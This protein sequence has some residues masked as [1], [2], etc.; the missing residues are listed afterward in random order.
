MKH[1]ISYSIH[2]LGKMYLLE[3]FED[4]SPF[5]LKNCMHVPYLERIREY[6]Q[7][8]KH[9]SVLI[10]CKQANDPGDAQQREQDHCTL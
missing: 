4:V 10:H 3:E 6:K 1:K 8:S 5:T 7:P 2:N 9:L